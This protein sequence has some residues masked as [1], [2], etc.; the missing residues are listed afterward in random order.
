ML[1]II[2][3]IITTLMVWIRFFFYRYTYARAWILHFYYL[4]DVT[5]LRVFTTLFIIVYFHSQLLFIKLPFYFVFTLVSSYIVI[6]R[7]GGARSIR[8]STYLFVIANFYL[9]IS[10][11]LLDQKRSFIYAIVTFRFWTVVI[12]L[13]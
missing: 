3:I 1:C 12:L 4:S 5:T 11:R 6:V 2:I 7:A 9:F 13:N 10:L 8:F